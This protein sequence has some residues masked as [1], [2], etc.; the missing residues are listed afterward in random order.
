MYL[1]Y[2]P[3]SD[4][5]VIQPTPGEMEEIKALADALAPARA[6]IQRLFGGAPHG[7]HAES[8]PYIMNFIDDVQALA[9]YSSGS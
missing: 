7:V 9:R 4:L 6:V 3:D 1:I 5:T 2:I 8:L